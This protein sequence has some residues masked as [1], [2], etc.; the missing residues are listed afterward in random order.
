MLSPVPEK[1]GVLIQFRTLALLPRLLR[2]LDSRT[3]YPSLHLAQ[4]L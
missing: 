2:S 1:P 4:C 3:P